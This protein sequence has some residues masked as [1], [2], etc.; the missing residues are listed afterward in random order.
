MGGQGAGAADG[1]GSV[2]FADAVQGAFELFAAGAGF[3]GQVEEIELA[4]GVGFDEVGDA[5]ADE[6]DGLFEGDFLEEGGGHGLEVIFHASGAGKR[7][8]TGEGAEIFPAKLEAPGGRQASVGT[9][10]AGDIPD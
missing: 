7:T 3:D 9:Q 10:A 5:E 4:G 8:L 2:F 6:A 1:G